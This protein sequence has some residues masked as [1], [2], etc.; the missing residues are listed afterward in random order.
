LL[1]ESRQGR[2]TDE[3]ARD[4]AWPRRRRR[5]HAPAQAAGFKW[6]D[7]GDVRAMDPYTLD[8]TVQNLFL[9]NIH[10]PLVRRSKTLGLEPALA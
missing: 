8:E 9:A 3:V 2:Q 4:P 6:A 10:E 1:E 5:Y 7:D